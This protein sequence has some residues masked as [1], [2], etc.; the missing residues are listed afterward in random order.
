M[1]YFFCIIFPPLA[2]ISTGKFLAFILNLILS[3]CFVIPGIIHAFIVV[4]RFYA[5]RRHKEVLKAMK[6]NKVTA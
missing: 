2:V 3:L 4:N 5:D 6:E 1:R